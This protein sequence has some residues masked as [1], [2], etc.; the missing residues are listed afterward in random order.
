MVS[1]L[2]NGGSWVQAPDGP[3]KN[4][5]IGICCF[6][7]KHAALRSKCKDWLAQ[8]YDNVYEWMSHVYPWTVISQNYESL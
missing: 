3:N 5:K 1:V 7:T 4:I 6:S 8:N 2:K